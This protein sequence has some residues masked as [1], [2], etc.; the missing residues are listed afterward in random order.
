MASFNLLLIEKNNNK[1]EGDPINI[2]LLKKK[3]L[4][5]L[6]VS[7]VS[8]S[9]LAGPVAG[10]EVTK[11]LECLSG[12]RNEIMKELDEQEQDIGEPEKNILN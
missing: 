11:M 1:E 3:V 7:S 4:K 8:F 5:F 2:A 12:Y 9:L 6:I 10:N